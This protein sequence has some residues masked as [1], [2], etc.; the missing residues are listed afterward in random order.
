MT[1]PVVFHLVRQRCVECSGGR[2]SGVRVLFAGSSELVEVECGKSPVGCRRGFTCPFCGGSLSVSFG[3][4]FCSAHVFDRD[5]MK[6]VDVSCGAEGVIDGQ[7]ERRPRQGFGRGW[8]GLLPV[9][10]GVCEHRPPVLLPE[11]F[12]RE[13]G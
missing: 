11:R 3:R 5:R 6:I 9:P 2:G 13:V 4:A 10:L 8:S 1:R 12:V 7:W